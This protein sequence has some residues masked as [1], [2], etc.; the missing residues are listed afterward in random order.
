MNHCQPEASHHNVW[1]QQ[2]LQLLASSGAVT[3]VLT[4]AASACSCLSRDL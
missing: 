4:D 1:S 3:M 2:H